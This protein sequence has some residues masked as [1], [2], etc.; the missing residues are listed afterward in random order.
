MSNHKSP[1]VRKLAL[2]YYFENN[3]SQSKIS[4]M[5]KITDRT[6]RNWLKKYNENKSYER[7]SGNASSYK[8]KEK[9]V[10]YLLKIIKI[11]KRIQL[12]QTI[13]IR[14]SLFNYF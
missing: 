5:F 4:S 7:M 13:P 2:E 3:V 6:F 10:K 1:D 11:I 14:N 9:H 8:I 12:G